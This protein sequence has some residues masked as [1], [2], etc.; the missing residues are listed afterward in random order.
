MEFPKICGKPEKVD[1]E[2]SCGI[3]IQNR[4]AFNLEKKG[5]YK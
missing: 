4:L 3:K 2:K 5:Y 1:R